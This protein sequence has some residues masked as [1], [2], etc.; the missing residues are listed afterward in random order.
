[1][2]NLKIKNRFTAELPADPNE[3][4]EIRQ[5]SNALFSYVNPEK[6]SNPKLIHASEDVAELVGISKDEI[7]SEAFLNVFSG[8]DILPETRPY[9]MCYA[10]HQ[11]GN[12]AGQ[13]GDGRAI[14]LTEIEH[15]NQ[16]FTLQLKGAGK[17]PYS[18]TADGLAVLRSS[19]REYLCAEAMHYLGVP[20]TRSLSLMLSG[21]EVLRDILYN[22]NPAYEKGAIVCRVAPSFIRFGSFEMI[23]SRN[24]L[25]NLKQFAEYTIKHYFPEIKGEPKDQ[26]IQFFKTV[27]DTTREMILH[28]QRVGFVHGVMNTDNMSIHGI[29]IDYGPYGWL[30]NYDPNWTPNTTDSQNRRYRFGNQPQVAQWNL[31]QLANALYPLINEAKPLEDILESFMINFDNDYKTMFLSK[32][33]LLTSTE[34]DN[35]LIA[36]LESNLQMS[37]TDMTIFFR[38]L[39]AV[40]KEDTVEKAFNKIKDAFYILDEISNNVLEN[41][42]N[43]FSSYLKRLDIE[44]LSNEDRAVKMNAVN[45]KYVLRNYMA[46]LSIDA[47]DQG[48]YSLVNELYIL[49]QK[50][51]EEQPEMEKWFAK[52]PDWA[53]SKVGCSMLSCSS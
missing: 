10:G 52:R 8:K 47:A 34:T 53:R 29:T 16:F 17:T 6:P 3:T 26:Y 13:L 44:N 37:E 24:E 36:D 4:N 50:P 25:K 19:I 27:A 5:V 32:L 2:K 30:E 28:W 51:Y 48:D 21:D 45:P 18:R 12:W 35:E 40:K 31:F 43:W 22:G 14:N 23:T 49:L 38:N 9:A 42:T 20:T 33:G 46:Q 1:M 15:N 11:F 39:S 7:Q 41:W